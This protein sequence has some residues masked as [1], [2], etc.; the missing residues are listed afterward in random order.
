[1][2]DLAICIPTYNEAENIGPLLEQLRSLYAYP[3]LIVIDDGSTDGTI[4][5]VEQIK[6]RLPN[7]LLLRRPKKD[8]LGQAYRAG[9]QLALGR[10]AR[11]V[12]QMDGDL[13]HPP[14]Y[15][16]P[17][18]DAI[19]GADLVIGSRYIPGGACEGW[20]WHRRTLS[21]LGNLY[22]RAFV[23]KAVHDLTGG[24][25]MWRREAL[26]SID[27][28]AINSRGYAFQVELKAQTLAA[29]LRVSEIPIRFLERAGSS[30]KMTLRIICEA[31]LRIPT[32]RYSRRNSG[33]HLSAIPTLK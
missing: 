4:E 24:F 31:V 25:N 3:L 11:F 6:A 27:W 23:S 21:K 9:F 7:I 30:S 18:Y 16:L 33:A 1:M 8:G 19:H 32:M 22:A 10:G 26:Q 15:I 28:T 29:R 14:E 13:S 2:Q 5:I 17:L 20:A 12:C